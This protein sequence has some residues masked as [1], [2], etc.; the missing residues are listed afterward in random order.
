VNQQRVSLGGRVRN[1]APSINPSP[2]PDTRRYSG[3]RGLSRRCER[4]P[5]R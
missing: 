2:C 5:E 4:I 1:G 3:S